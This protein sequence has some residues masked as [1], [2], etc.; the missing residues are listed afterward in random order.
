MMKQINKLI[1]KVIQEIKKPS[2]SPPKLIKTSN[3][4]SLRTSFQ[5]LLYCHVD[6]KKGMNHDFSLVNSQF[7]RTIIEN[8]N[9]FAQEIID[10][11]EQIWLEDFRWYRDRLDV[12][13]PPKSSI[14]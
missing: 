14:L 3:S 1:I 2:E 8:H 10:N 5:A 9:K 7:G 11:K 6:V 12:G 4:V 13:K